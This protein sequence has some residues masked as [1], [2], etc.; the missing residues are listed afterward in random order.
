MKKKIILNAGIY[1][2][3]HFGHLKLLRSMKAAGNKLIIVIHDDWSSFKIKDKIPIQDLKHRINNLKITGI[4][5][6]IIITRSVDPAGEFEKV[7]NKYKK[8]ELVYMRGDDLKENFPGQ[9]ML[10]KHKI[11]IKFLPYTTG[12]SSTKIKDMLIK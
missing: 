4:P 5:D 11:P 6:E 3:C 8:Q 7:I 10:N 12:V 2:L 9:W 1:D